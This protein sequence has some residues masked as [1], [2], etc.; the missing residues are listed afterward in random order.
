M[1]GIAAVTEN[2]LFHFR[3]YLLYRAALFRNA[4]FLQFLQLQGICL[5]NHRL[6]M[7]FML[8][9]AKIMYKLPHCILKLLCIEYKFFSFHGMHSFIRNHIFYPI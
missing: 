3:H 9:C 2:F 4:N 8:V 5:L 7:D 1:V 6:C